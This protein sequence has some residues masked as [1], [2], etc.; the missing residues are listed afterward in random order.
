MIWKGGFTVAY[1]ANCGPQLKEGA[2]V[3]INCGKLVNQRVNIDTSS[4]T[5]FIIFGFLFAFI[6]LFFYPPVFGSL[7][8]WFGT[9][10]KKRGKDGL[11][12]TLII[13]NAATMV[14]GMIIGVLVNT[15][16][17]G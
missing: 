15:G 12:L 14:V 2:D 8:I 7:G 16:M 10:V 4:P 13:L 9:I 3:C 1:C 5:A 6:A 17:M 11:G